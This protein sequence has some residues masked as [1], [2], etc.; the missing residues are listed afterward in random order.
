MLSTK[1]HFIQEEKNA[2]PVSRQLQHSNVR[3]IELE[4][5]PSKL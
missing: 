1:I 3:N 2:M 4:Q 5:I